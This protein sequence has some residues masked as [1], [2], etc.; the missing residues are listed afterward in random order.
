LVV[1]LVACGSSSDAPTPAPTNTGACATLTAKDCAERRDC[2]L[3]RDKGAIACRAAAGCELR[4]S[5][6]DLAPLHLEPGDWYTKFKTTCE[7]DPKCV[8][9][10]RGCFC[11]CNLSGFPSCNC[12]CGGGLPARC[13]NR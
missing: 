3:D 6:A 5:A 2:L 1:W 11:P 13:A 10:N 4:V 9:E 7:Q 8:Y 12:D